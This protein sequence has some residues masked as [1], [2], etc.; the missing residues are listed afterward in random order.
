MLAKAYS[1]TNNQNIKKKNT[2]KTHKIYSTTK[3]NPSKNKV[4][5]L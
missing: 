3:E 5:K 4:R 1:K 2:R